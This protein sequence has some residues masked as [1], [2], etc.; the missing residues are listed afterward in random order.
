MDIISFLSN[1]TSLKKIV[2]G[3]NNNNLLSDKVF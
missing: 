3:L 1:I 2:P